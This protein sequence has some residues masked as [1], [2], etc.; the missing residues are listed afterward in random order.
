MLK[1]ILISI[2][3]GYLASW[4]IH[5]GLITRLINTRYYLKQGHYGVRQAWRI[6]GR[7]L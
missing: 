3:T 7:T 4:V 5:G 2:G 1:T 6:A